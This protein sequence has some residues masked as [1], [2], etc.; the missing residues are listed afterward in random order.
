MLITRIELENIKSYRNVAVDFRRGTTAISGANGA[1]KTTLVEAI[2]YALFDSL[3]YNQTQFVREGEKYGRVTVHLI[4]G[5]DRP[6]IVERRCGSGGRWTLTDVEANEKLEQRIDVQ[7]RLHDICGIDRERP[8]NSLFHDALGVPQGTFTA[9]FL[10]KPSARK[11]TFDALLQ[12]EDYKVA[13]DYLLEA[14]KQYKEQIQEQLGEIKRLEYETRDLDQQREDLRQARVLDEQQKLQNAEGNQQLTRHE[15]RNLVLLKQ[16]EE[17]KELQHAFETSRNTHTSHQRVLYERTQALEAARRAQQLVLASTSDYE[18]YQQAT[19]RLK[20]LRQDE[21][22]RNGLRQQQ[23]MRQ[24]T[25]ATSEAN[26]K[27]WRTRL[28][29][30]A[31]ARQRLQELL[32]LV[33]QQEQLEQQRDELIQQFSR[34]NSVVDEG[35][36]LSRLQATAKD[37]QDAVQKRI[38]EIEPLQPLA[39]VMMERNEVLNQLRMQEKERSSIALQLQKQ[40]DQLREKLI[41]RDKV[42]ENLRKS[43]QNVEIIEAHRSEAEEMPALQERFEQAVALKNRLEG[44]IETGRKWRTQSVGGNC[45]LLQ[46]PCLNIKQR[47]AVSLEFYFDGLIQDERTQLLT[48]KKEQEGIHERMNAIKKYVDALGK[49]GLYIEKRDSHAQQLQRIAQDIQRLERDVQDL[50]TELEAL[51]Q[52]EQQIVAAEAAFQESKRAYDQVGQLLGL[53]QQVQQFQ[54][55]SHQYELELQ[56]LR[57]EAKT[58]QGSEAQLKQVKADLE[59]LRD[60]RARSRAQESI[61]VQEET[62]QRRLHQE[63]QQWQETQ[64]QLHTLNEQLATYEQLDGDIATQ[65]ATLHASTNGYQNYLQNRLEARALPEREQAQQQQQSV[66]EQAELAFQRAEQAYQSAAA[67]FHREELETVTKEIARLATVLAALAENMQHHQRYMNELE[68]RIAYAEELGKQLEV[69]QKEKQT[70]EDLHTTMNQFRSL[71]KEAAPYVLKAMLGDISAEANRIFGEI[72][73]DRSAQL[74][75]QGDYEIVLRRQGANRSF[76]QLS[77]GEQMSA[78]LAVRLALLKKLSTLNL[79]F[80]DEPTQNMDE[81]RRMNLAEQIRRVRGFEQLI[82]ISH[83]DTFEQGLDSLVRLRKS[84][85]TTYIVEEDEL[86][87]EVREQTYV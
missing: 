15:A 11:Q 56:E 32:P 17:L 12:I 52:V 40:R 29:E 68:Q 87:V 66:T 2:G 72:M 60:P 65:E 84:D 78:A 45:P 16:Q 9:I 47:G 44:S 64:Q 38:G 43:E 80:F 36:K 35:K 14:Q 48:A 59:Q 34:Y 46:E 8:L 76:A 82:V 26:I 5:D 28:E 67:N 10:E 13:A 73:G 30:V 18:R 77:G 37:K 61:I 22:Q 41:E 50:S 31:S 63:E 6:Y 58:L 21:Q 70:L 3:P 74:S 49:L 33:S 53:Q 24:K 83:D 85:G 54:A 19:E 79:A 86:R 39:H 42:A 51:K 69:A 1:G 55:Q 27:N 23:A 25:A 7:D 57:Q 4:G 75:W 62:Y 71:I 81:L 20:H